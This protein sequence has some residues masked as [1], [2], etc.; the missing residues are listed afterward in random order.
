VSFLPG[1][2]QSKKYGLGRKIMA[3]SAKAVVFGGESKQVY[4]FQRQE[5]EDKAMLYLQ[6]AMTD[7]SR[8][9]GVE[10]VHSPCD[11]SV[12]TACMTS[13]PVHQSYIEGYRPFIAITRSQMYPG[14]KNKPAFKEVELCDAFPSPKH[15]DFPILP[16]LDINPLYRL[17]E[18][19]SS[20]DHDA[21]QRLAFGIAVGLK[22]FVMNG[23]TFITC[24]MLV[25]A[26]AG[27]TSFGYSALY[28]SA[29]EP[30]YNFH[31]KSRGK[32]AIVLLNGYNKIGKN[33]SESYYAVEQYTLEDVEKLLGIEKSAGGSP[34]P[35]AV[36]ATPA[37][38]T[39]ERPVELPVDATPAASESPSD[40]QSFSAPDGDIKLPKWVKKSKSDSD[41]SDSDA[42]S[43]G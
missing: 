38:A 8:S 2:T 34:L 13:E 27:T 3:S 17:L 32:P 1:L 21:V 15:A 40:D 10:V 9:C 28:A 7:L 26:D 31:M 14:Y 33:H 18:L 4:N 12:I 37:T 30:I 23:K 16:D 24:N 41:K 19:P 6:T 42:G 36:D 11:P 22:K 39:S 25:P 5:F 43:N 35:S 29:V 20:V